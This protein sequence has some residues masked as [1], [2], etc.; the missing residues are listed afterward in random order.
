LHRL[1]SALV[2]AG[3]TRD[4]RL[5]AAL[6]RFEALPAPVRSEL[7]K[8]LK[9]VSIDLLALLPL[10]CSLQEATSPGDPG[11]KQTP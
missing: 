10:V 1:S 3:L 11:P 9:M 6:A 7:H 8:E 4:E 5:D 2:N